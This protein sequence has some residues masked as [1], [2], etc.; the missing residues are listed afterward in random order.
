[1]LDIGKLPL[2]LTEVA[3]PH[4]LAFH[5]SLIRIPPKDR[6]PLRF[7]LS[8]SLEIG[9]VGLV[10]RSPNVTPFLAH[11]AWNE[12]ATQL[13]YSAIILR[14]ESRVPAVTCAEQHELSA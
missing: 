3:V 8:S 1:M 4:I 2:L 9:A 7:T 11:S 6:I 13:L 14:G 12:I 10:R 5:Q